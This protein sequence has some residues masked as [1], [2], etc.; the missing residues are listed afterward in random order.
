MSQHHLG[1]D[2]GHADTAVALASGRDQD[3]LASPA[4]LEIQGQTIQP[5]ALVR[6]AERVLIGTR[7][8][9]EASKGEGGL[10]VAFKARP[11]D[12]GAARADLADYFR[13]VLEEVAFTP[14]PPEGWAGCAVAVGCPSSWSAGE[15]ARAYAEVLREG[16]SGTPMSDARVSV[17]PESRAALLQAIENPNSPLTTEARTQNILVIDIGSSTLDMSLIAPEQKAAPLID[18]GLDLGASFFDRQVLGH[19]LEGR[20]DARGFLDLNPHYRDLWLYYARRSK[21]Q[22]FLDAPTD[23]REAVSGAPL[24]TF[25]AGGQRR[26]LT[27]DVTGEA[28]ARF[29]REPY[30]RPLNPSPVLEMEAGGDASWETRFEAGLRAMRAAIERRGEPYG[31]VLLA[32]GASRMPFTE[33][34][35]RGVFGEDAVLRDPE[36]SHMVSRGLARWSRRREGVERFAVAARRMTDDK[37][38]ALIAARFEPLRDR[39]AGALAGVVFDRFV[40]PTLAKWRAGAFRTG[41]DVRAEI[42]ARSAAWLASEE[43]T[44]LFVREINA[45]WRAEVKPE[46]DR[47][48]DALHASFDVSRDV[49]LRLAEAIDPALFRFSAR[50]ID[51]PFESVIQAALLALA[52]ALTIAIDAHFGFIPITTGALAGAVALGGKPLRAWIAT[53]DVPAFARQLPDRLPGR[54][55]LFGTRVRARVEKQLGSSLDEARASVLAQVQRAVRASVDQQTK[56]ARAMLHGE[57]GQPASKASSA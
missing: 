38:P 54:D 9:R 24:L 43:G 35:A 8:V 32:G 17:V 27:I 53:L 15:D 20:E 25:F 29:R 40:E 11:K 49:Q 51:L 5:T 55:Q 7:A 30:D 21:E 3:R 14:A 44:Q 19:A 34:I 46:V 13:T 47:E 33:E 41:K 37:L 45:W 57:E 23:P 36:P 4:S 10:H 42:E 39:L 56:R 26:T 16:L 6:E 48:L 2:L 50:D 1:F 52:F 28:M 12:L 18:A 31:K 22:W